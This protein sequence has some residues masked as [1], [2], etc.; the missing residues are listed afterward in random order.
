M[1]KQEYEQLT[2]KVNTYIEMGAR[3]GAYGVNDFA[4]IAVTLAKLKNY[5][6]CGCKEKKE[7]P[8]AEVKA[9]EINRLT[10]GQK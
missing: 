4:D 8:E 9:K 1:T 10:N 5:S 2:T 7:N 6:P 3:K